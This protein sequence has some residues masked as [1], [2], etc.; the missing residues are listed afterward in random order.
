MVDLPS[1]E[2]MLSYTGCPT[3]FETELVS[4][5]DGNGNSVDDHSW[6]EFDHDLTSQQST[7]SVETTDESVAGAYDVQLSFKY[8]GEPYNKKTTIDLLITIPCP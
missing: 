3:T 6:L 8:E 7:L 1:I 4:V 2:N 5:S